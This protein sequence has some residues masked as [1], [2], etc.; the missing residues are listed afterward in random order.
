MNPH[1]G[2]KAA[3]APKVATYG[4]P[5]CAPEGG[6][7]AAISNVASYEEP[8]VNT[9]KNAKAA[10]LVSPHAR[11]RETAPSGEEEADDVARF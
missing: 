11:A 8:P 3:T 6:P 9:T 5:L 7:K 1:R 2:P 10:N 4:A